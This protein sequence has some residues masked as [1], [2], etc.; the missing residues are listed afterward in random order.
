MQCGVCCVCV[1]QTHAV[2]R[3]AWLENI[4]PVL[5]L[6]KID[7]LIT[8][9]KMTTYEAYQHLQRTLEQ[10]NAITGE[11][12]TS[13]V[14]AKSSEVNILA[15]LTDIFTYILLLFISS[16]CVISL[17]GTAPILLLTLFLFFFLFFVLG[18]CS[19]NKSLRLGSVFFKLD[20]DEIWEDF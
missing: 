14:F 4:R 2:L 3:Q 12:F 10:V 15:A 6:N 8:E 19:S 13:D 16:S 11:L 5:V 7:R 20:R 1:T 17:L 18:L 9:W